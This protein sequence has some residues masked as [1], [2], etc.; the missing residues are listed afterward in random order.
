MFSPKLSALSPFNLPNRA[1]VQVGMQRTAIACF[2][3]VA[4]FQA[5]GQAQTDIH[6]TWTAEIHQGKVFLQVRTAPPP[7]SNRSGDW[8]GDWSMGQ[9]YPVDDL[10]GLPAN[11][12]RLTASS[13]KFE[14]RR[15]AG[16][17]SFDG[18]FRDG[19]GAG[20]FTFAPREA[21]TGEMRSLG[22]SETGAGSTPW[23]R[24]APSGV[25]WPPN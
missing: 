25:R 16:T 6:G 23:R 19:R 14:M 18:S 24:S 12:E 8:N 7:D 17:L 5:T 1:A 10:S 4:L 2:A 3:V 22:F 9:S 15:E 11:D 20:L 13:V 21:Y